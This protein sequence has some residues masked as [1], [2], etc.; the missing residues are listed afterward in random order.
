MGLAVSPSEPPEARPR[1]FRRRE[2]NAP[3]PSTAGFQ[4]SSVALRADALPQAPHLAK[5]VNRLI[6][7]PER[8]TPRYGLGV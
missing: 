5:L 6:D 3:T 2:L 1:P 4:L 7:G 8:P